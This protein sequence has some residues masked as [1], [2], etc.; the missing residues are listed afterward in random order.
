MWKFVISR[1]K[2]QRG[3]ISYIIIIFLSYL[4]SLISP[5]LNGKFVDILTTSKNLHTI[6]QYAIA[7]VII[8]FL[9][10][11]VSYVAS[12]LTVS[13]STKSSVSIIITTMK[14]ILETKL[15]IAEKFNVSY[16]TQRLFQDANAL[17]SFVLSNFISI[18][19]N[20]II[21][22]IIGFYFFTL[23]K[24][25]W[26][27]SCSLLLPYVI[28]FK[29]LKK[30]LYTTSEKKKE[31]DTQFF[32]KIHSN[33]NQI[34][35]IQ[36]FDR[37]GSAE[38]EAN[39]AFEDYFPYILKASKISY[40]FSSIDSILQVVFQSILFV[41]AGIEIA[42]NKMSI[43]EFI[44]VNS[45]FS[46]LLKSVKYYASFYKQYQDSLASYN[47]ILQILNYP[48]LDNGNVEIDHIENMEITNLNFTFDESA[49][50]IFKN[51]NFKFTQSKSYAIVG[52]NGCGKSTL[53]KIILGLYEHKNSIIIN[54]N[55]TTDLDWRKIR[56]KHISC[57]PQILYAP[58]I[59]VKEF[60]I[61]NLEC[62][63]DELQEKIVK[64]PFL[65]SYC[66]FLLNHLE[67]YCNTLSGGELRKMYLWFALQK[68]C[69]ILILDEPTSGLDKDSCNELIRYITKNKLE[70]TILII[71]HDTSI[72][73]S[74]DE[75]LD[76]KNSTINKSNVILN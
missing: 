39:V 30:P 49:T 25:L 18:F 34:M 4:I 51:T 65:K 67:S 19:F 40:L 6:C 15:I 50:P 54:N 60:L 23:N 43:G 59:T 45:Y 9:G 16:I 20:G 1:M 55:P 36:I 76:I 66:S 3:A 21:I 27:I 71:T 37:F 32:G 14:N 56:K 64:F 38:D 12:I 62:T 13:I 31:A 58:Q 73:N 69:E 47:R 75:V 2:K 29:I 28:L 10:A 41:F 17:T 44:M 5:Y 48:K 26:L 63:S 35:N 52:E 22:I 11:I 7:L 33:I 70:Q 72:I 74:A 42:L 53:I 68:G 61:E 46:L 57:V 8:G 24:L